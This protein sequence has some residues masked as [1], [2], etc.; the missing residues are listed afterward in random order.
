[1]STSLPPASVPPTPHQIAL[2][3]IAERRRADAD[4][5]TAWETALRVE[6][7]TTMT[8]H[9]GKSRAEAQLDLADELAATDAPAVDVL[10]AIVLT[11]RTVVLGGDADAIRRAMDAMDAAEASGD[12]TTQA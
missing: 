9:F 7:V 2:T 8:T 4:G 5:P 1:M 10:E 3:L 11:L 6:A 12:S